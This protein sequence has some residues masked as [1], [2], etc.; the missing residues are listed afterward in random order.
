MTILVAYWLPLI[1]LSTDPESSSESGQS[2]ESIHSDGPIGFSAN[3]DVLRNGKKI[4]ELNATL[5]QNESGLWYYR[6]ES[7]ATDWLVRMLGIS[8]LETSW[9]EWRDGRIRPLTYH[10]VSR[11][12]GRD[13]YWQHRYDWQAEQSATRT[14]EGE[15]EIPLTPQTL[16]P[17]TLRLAIASLLDRPTPSSGE[18]QFDV[19]ERDK[20]EQQSIRF[21]GRN[22][23]QVGSYCFDTVELYRFRR[24]GSSRNYRAWHAPALD[25]LAVKLR[26]DDDDDVIE[27]RLKNWQFEHETA[28]APDQF[29]CD[30]SN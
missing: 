29:N 26:H 5:S 30:K 12:P 20:I 27:M 11:E 15:F 2:I 25:G 6:L 28:P 18:W 8:T 22:T 9:L 4:G 16:D 7:V 3:Y 17:L 13:R 24:E 1:A 19:L 10:M 14:H 23:T 21:I